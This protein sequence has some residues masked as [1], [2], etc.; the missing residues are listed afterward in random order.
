VLKLLKLQFPP[1]CNMCLV[2]NKRVKI[3]FFEIN[4]VVM[5]VFLKLRLW[6]CLVL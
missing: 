2:V 1:S 4:R 5:F 3:S 6:V